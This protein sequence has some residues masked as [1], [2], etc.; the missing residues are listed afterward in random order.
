MHSRAVRALARQ[1]RSRTRRA[2][3]ASR[4]T[5]LAGSDGAAERSPLVWATSAGKKPP[6]GFT[7]QASESD[8][9]ATVRGLVASSVNSR[10]ADHMAWFDGTTPAPGECLPQT[11]ISNRVEKGLDLLPSSDSQPREVRASPFGGT[12]LRPLALIAVNRTSARRPG[13]L[14]E[15]RR[16]V[17]AEARPSK[18]ARGV[19][20]GA[21]W[22]WAGSIRGGCDARFDRRRQPAL[23]APGSRR[24]SSAVT[25]SSSSL[26]R[27]EMAGPLSGRQIYHGA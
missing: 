19:R 9:L 25:G 12:R 16:Y 26:A 11:A 20:I 5:R 10:A 4:E 8:R 13:A 22:R 6:G 24:R 14:A 2:R 3:A 18:R 1:P 27:Q 23:P 7:R 21:R 17:T 15:R